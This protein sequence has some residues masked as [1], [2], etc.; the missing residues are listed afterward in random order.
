MQ[1]NTGTHAATYVDFVCQNAALPET[2]KVWT[3]E[4]VPAAFAVLA[5]NPGMRSATIVREFAYDDD[6]GRGPRPLALVLDLSA[7]VGRMNIVNTTTDALAVDEYDFLMNDDGTAQI[8][9]DGMRSH[10]DMAEIRV[11]AAEFSALAH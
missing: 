1:T 6:D 10:R 11:R 3:R 4:Q 9:C 7:T 8:L 5:A 2:V